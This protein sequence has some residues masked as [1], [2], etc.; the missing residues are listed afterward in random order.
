MERIFQPL[1]TP[2]AQQLKTLLRR[3]AGAPTYCCKTPNTQPHAGRWQK[4]F[5][6]DLFMCTLNDEI[7]RVNQAFSTRVSEENAM[8]THSAALVNSAYY[9]GKLTKAKK[10]VDQ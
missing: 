9:S 3:F 10:E 5:P 7:F 6:T 8:Q 4:T 2:G 1:S